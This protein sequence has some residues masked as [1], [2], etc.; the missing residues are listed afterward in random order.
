ME[1]TNEQRSIAVSFKRTSAER[2]VL[3]GET[4]KTHRRSEDLIINKIKRREQMFSPLLF[5]MTNFV[6]YSLI[7]LK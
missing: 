2:P 6:R 3:D 1:G 7:K 4:I 5:L